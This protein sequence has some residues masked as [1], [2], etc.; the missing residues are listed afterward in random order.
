MKSPPKIVVVKI[1]LATY[2]VL[3][4]SLLETKVKEVNKD[5]VMMKISSKWKSDDNYNYPHRGRIWV[6]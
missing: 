5:K 4:I 6:A 1:D 3:Y 2:K